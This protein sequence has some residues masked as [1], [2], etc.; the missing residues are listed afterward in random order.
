[1]LDHEHAVAHVAQRLQRVE[2]PRIVA[3][4]QP[5]RGLVQHIEHAGQARADL[6]R[7]PDALA[8]AAGQRAAR[9]RQREIIEADIVEEG[10]P[11]ADLLQDARGDLVLLRGEVRGQVGEPVRRL[12]DRHLRDLA[13]MQPGD[14]D[15]QRLRLQ[16]IAAAGLAGMIRLV[17][18]QLL[19]HPGGFGLAPAPL[20]IGDDALE[21]LGGRIVAHA[22]VIGEGDLVVA[23]AVQDHVPERLGQ[24]LPRLGHRLAIGAGERFKRLLV[25]GRGGAGPRPGRDRA[26]RE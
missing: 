21:R 25:I 26:A 24:L 3:L 7:E 14:L 18:R 5:D 15:R 11:L 2:Q 4:M 9:A 6:R 17:A 19:A 8:L 12:P 22:V 10:E 16:A 20:D 23:R 13:D 1:M